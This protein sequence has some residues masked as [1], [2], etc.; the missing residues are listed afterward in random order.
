MEA[1]GRRVT[2][3]E[4][5]EGRR[6]GWTEGEKSKRNLGRGEEGMYKVKKNRKRSVIQ[7][8]TLHEIALMCIV[9]GSNL[10]VT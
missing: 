5:K 9:S 8:R 10:K 6:K 3:R 1:S 7:C 4:R 2:S